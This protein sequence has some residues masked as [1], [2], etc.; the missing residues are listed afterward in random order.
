MF[1]RFQGPGTGGQPRLMT[2][3]TISLDDIVESSD[4][5]NNFGGVWQHEV[6]IELNKYS[7]MR[8]VARAWI[9]TFRSEVRKKLWD[10][11]TGWGQWWADCKLSLHGN[12]SY[13]KYC[14][15]LKHYKIFHTLIATEA[16]SQNN[17][18]LSFLIWRKLLI[19]F[20]AQ[21]GGR[22]PTIFSPQGGTGKQLF[23]KQAPT[24]SANGILCSLWKSVKWRTATAWCSCCPEWRAT[25]KPPCDKQT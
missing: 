6:R 5:K 17:H 22:F 3:A 8:K 10:T 12:G 11:L 7:S 9:E 25:R 2:A 21:L 24:E 4:G 13:I 14:S 19:F 16:L 1:P 20:P 18:F 15:W 23:R